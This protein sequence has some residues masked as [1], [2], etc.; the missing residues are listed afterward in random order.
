MTPE[1]LS[2][3]CRF[4]E[5]H[6]LPGDTDLADRVS[7]AIAALKGEVVGAIMAPKRGPG[8]PRKDRSTLEGAISPL[9]LSDFSALVQADL[10][11]AW[12][13]AQGGDDGWAKMLRK[14]CR[15]K[16]ASKKALAQGS[17]MPQAFQVAWV[18]YCRGE[19]TSCPDLGN[20]MPGGIDYAGG[21]Q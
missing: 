6:V 1:R 16:V 8:R 2:D 13:K 12:D 11:F 15:D 9:R 10:R 4:L 18:E 7:R 20:F 14:A 5:S 17:T 3:V 19:R 21:V